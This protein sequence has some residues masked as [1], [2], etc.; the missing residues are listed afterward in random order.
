MSEPVEKNPQN[1][2]LAAKH[3][4][5]LATE[6]KTAIAEQCEWRDWEHVAND[7]GQRLGLPWI[8]PHH[9]HTAVIALGIQKGDVKRTKKRGRPAMPK[10][11]RI[12]QRVEDLERRLALV[13]A[14]LQ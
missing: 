10:A 2:R 4:F 3:L 9:V 12:T 6:L 13:E 1:R 5:D 14:L 7:L 11:L 8:A